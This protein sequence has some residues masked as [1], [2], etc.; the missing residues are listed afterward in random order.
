MVI[1]S[2]GPVSNKNQ[3][4]SWLLFKRDI[5][6]PPGSE[7]SVWHFQ[8]SFLCIF[9]FFI[10]IECV[11]SGRVYSQ[12]V[13]TRQNRPEVWKAFGINSWAYFTQG[14]HLR[15]LSLGELSHQRWQSGDRWLW[16][17]LQRREQRRDEQPFHQPALPTPVLWPGWHHRWTEAVVH[18]GKRGDSEPATSTPCTW[19][20]PVLLQHEERSSD[21][22]HAQSRWLLT[23][24]GPCLQRHFYPGLSPEEQGDG[25][26]AAMMTDV[27]SFFGPTSGLCVYDCYSI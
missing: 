15:A 8:L 12:P 5:V 11:S 16:T 23:T 13:R 17:L 4:R 7:V 24:L 2:A 22:G 10:L 3:S 19:S 9:Y 27:R 6:S 18:G 25:K 26:A 20:S 1:N 14:D 21:P